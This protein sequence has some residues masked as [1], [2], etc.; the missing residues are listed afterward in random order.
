MRA[1]VAIPS[2]VVFRRVDTSLGGASIIETKSGE[3][4]SC[5]A[6]FVALRRRKGCFRRR[7]AD[8]EEDEIDRRRARSLLCIVSRVRLHRGRRRTVSRRE[9]EVV[10]WISSDALHQTSRTTT[11]LTFSIHTL[12]ILFSSISDFDLLAR[13]RCFMQVIFKVA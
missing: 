2:F 13:W 9:S 11:I 7:N 1:R 4:A 6:E 12:S 8:L 10:E 3:S 5:F